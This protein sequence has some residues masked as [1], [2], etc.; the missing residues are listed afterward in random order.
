MKLQLVTWRDAHFQREE[1]A[2]ERPPKDYRMKTVGWTKK[3]G[4]WL[5]IRSEK[6]T[7]ES[8]AGWR[9]ITRVPIENV[10]RRQTLR[11]K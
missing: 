2:G 8:G 6:D 5:V 10:I 1:G 11:T 9:A 3:E 7:D 4:R